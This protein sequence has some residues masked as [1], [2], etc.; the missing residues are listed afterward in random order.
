MRGGLA[1]DRPPTWLLIG[2]LGLAVVWVVKQFLLDPFMTTVEVLLGAM[3][4]Y[5]GLKFIQYIR[6]DPL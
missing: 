1:H 6:S 4:V 2:V 5:T 3:V